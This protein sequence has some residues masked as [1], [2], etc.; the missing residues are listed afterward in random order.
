MTVATISNVINHGRDSMGVRLMPDNLDSGYCHI[1]TEVA[2]VRTNLGGVYTSLC[3][4]HR[5]ALR[6]MLDAP[7]PAPVLHGPD[8]HHVGAVAPYRD[9][10]LNY[11]GEHVTTVTPQRRGANF[12]VTCTCGWT[13]GCA[14][15]NPGFA[16]ESADGHLRDVAFARRP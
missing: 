15:T 6:A 3:D 11:E 16:Q 8:V 4:A 14:T 9:P 7:A 1:C 5:D 10:Y 12:R 2:V 13:V